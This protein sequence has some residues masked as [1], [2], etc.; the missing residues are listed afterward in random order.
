MAA[1]NR[2][3]ESGASRPTS[4]RHLLG[5]LLSILAL[6][7][8]VAPRA[9][10]QRP[11]PAPS[12]TDTRVRRSVAALTVAE[13]K[14]FVDAVLAMKRAPSP[15]NSSLSYYDQFAQW[16]KDRYVCHPAAHA[17]GSTMP[18]VHAGP[19]FLPWHREL[20]RRFE[21]ALGEVSGKP[22]TVPYWDW[23]DS[24]SVNPDN[25]QSVFR[26][27]FMGGSGS[28]SDDYAVT[29]GP[30]RKGEW[31]LNV[32]PEGA[33]WAPSKTVYLTRH[34]GNVSTLPT[35]AD[36]D[37]AFA[38]DVYDVPPFNLTSDRGRSFRNALEGEFAANTMACGADGW[39]G[40]RPSD[41]GTPATSNR[42]T[43]HNMVHPWVA[44]VISQGDPR[45]ARRGTMI[46]STSPNDPV[47][48][49][50]HANVDRLWASWQARH[51]GRTYE[52]KTGHEGNNADSPMVP[53]GRVTPQRVEN[54]ADL[55]Y[56]YE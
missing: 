25:P 38:A 15:Y 12:A 27:D 19:M 18:I 16:H 2:G 45:T 37:K 48:F 21:D 28:P 17:D 9:A 31:A 6:V 10:R 49:L 54:I 55:G 39:M 36:V 52:P 35:K 50:H 8:T 13:R 14:D 23:T 34:L 22:V 1:I 11:S 41:P 33:F 20:L 3:K 26:D 32:H 56:R 24:E 30:F 4:R 5:C 46:L 40:P 29:T 47:F 44:G 42:L 43:L 53:F 7:V 51:P